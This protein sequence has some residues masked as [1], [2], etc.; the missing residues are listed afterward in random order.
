MRK[1][2]SIAIAQKILA[3]WLNTFQRKNVKHFQIELNKYVK[4]A[5]LS[6]HE[7]STELKQNMRNYFFFFTEFRKEFESI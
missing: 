3:S 7:F 2:N 6:Q 4:I 5:C 1:F